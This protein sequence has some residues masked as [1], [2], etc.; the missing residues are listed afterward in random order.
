MQK[1]QLDPP[2][3]DEEF[4]RQ[5][6][7]VDDIYMFLVEMQKSSKMEGGTKDKEDKKEVDVSVGLR[8][9][10]FL[11]MKRGRV[12]RKSS[13]GRSSRKSTLKIPITQMPFM[14]Q[15]DISEEE[16]RKARKDRMIVATNFR[17]IGNMEYRKSNFDQAIQ[18]YTRGI[19]YIVDSPVLYVNRSL[20]YIKKREYKRALIDLDYVL[21]NLNSSCVQAL[22]C[23]A[24][25]LKRMNDEAGYEECVSNARRYN[26]S[27][28]A[29][30]DNFLDKMRTDF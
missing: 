23:K 21:N 10:S 6:S 19:S 24:G 22:L 26:K 2:N 13:F 30:I 18:H 5:P 25:T 15:I 14:R 12:S 3:F 11:V 27:K 7:K 29:Y 20:C 4:L 9:N 28:T 1:T 17:R 8:D 16:R